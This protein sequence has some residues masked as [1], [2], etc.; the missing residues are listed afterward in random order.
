MKKGTRLDIY[1]AE[2]GLSASR[3]KARR[4]ILA[5]WVRVGGETVREPS[6]LVPGGRDV[7]VERPGSVF[8]SRGGEKL[9]HALDLFDIDVTGRVVADLG[10]STGG[11]TDCLLQKGASLVYAVD[12]G[13]GQLDYRLGSDPRVVVMDR[14][15][16]RHLT[17]D[18]FDRIVDF[19][20]ADLSFIS[21]LKMID[22]ILEVFSP[23]EGLLLIKPQF[24]AGKEEQKKGVV[25]KSEHHTAILARVIP[26]LVEKG[27]AVRGL[28]YSPIKGPAGN[29]E[30][31]LHFSAGALDTTPLALSIKE[32]GERIAVIVEEAH[33]R[34][35]ARR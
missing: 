10:A 34:L 2:Q 16:A 17:R 5:G 6:R 15:N 32:I 35:T 30:F 1:L 24:E 7:V 21:I 33:A 23:I 31:F 12:V 20:T 18:R 14:T 22:V 13:Y 28:C 27:I 25:R 9:L 19:L 8:A 3:E 26:A 4:E 11:F 29:I